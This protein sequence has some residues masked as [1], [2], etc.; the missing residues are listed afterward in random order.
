MF[1]VKIVLEN[2]Y[3]IIILKGFITDLPTLN[4]VFVLY[5][6]INLEE[7]ITDLGLILD[8]KYINPIHYLIRTQEVVFELYIISDTIETPQVDKILSF[9]R[10]QS[11]MERT[12]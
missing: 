6:D 9:F 1:K 7:P 3:D 12:I 2:P 8:V 5:T 10:G 11:L 4:S